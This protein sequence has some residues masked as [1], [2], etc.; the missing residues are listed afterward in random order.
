MMTLLRRTDSVLCAVFRVQY[1]PVSYHDWPALITELENNAQGP[2]KTLGYINPY[3]VNQSDRDPAHYTH[4][5]F[6]EAV[7]K[8]YFVKNSS[9]QPYLIDSVTFVFGT[10]DVTNPAARE[11]Y[12]AIIID[13]MLA[14]GM[15]QAGW[16]CDFGEYI[17]YD[18]VLDSGVPASVVHNQ[19]VTYTHTP[20]I[21][22]VRTHTP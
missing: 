16:M 11:W 17:P 21:L 3:L 15:Q 18:A 22:D 13:N 1:D 4:N 20:T 7:A 6:D 19:Y 2:I 12:K 8:G 14:S 5:Y 9:G 10:I